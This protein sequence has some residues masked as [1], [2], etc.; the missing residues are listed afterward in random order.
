MRQ[1]LRYMHGQRLRWFPQYTGCSGLPY[2]YYYGGFRASKKP[3]PLTTQ[4]WPHNFFETQNM[5]KIQ[6]QVLNAP[7]YHW[8]GN[9]EHPAYEEMLYKIQFHKGTQ[10]VGIHVSRGISHASYMHVVY[11]YL[12]KCLHFWYV[13]CMVRKLFAIDDGGKK[14]TKEWAKSRIGVESTTDIIFM[15]LV[16]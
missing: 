5:T 13:F 10:F 2:Q 9:P 4:F 15:H 14:R 12:F 8:H 16:V 11:A 6:I 3:R 1:I 7:K